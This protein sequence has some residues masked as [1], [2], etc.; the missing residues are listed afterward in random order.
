L[1]DWLVAVGATP[2][3]GQIPLYD[4]AHSVAQTTPPTQ[5]WIYLPTNVNDSVT[6]NRT[7]TQY[8]TFNTPVEAAADAQCGRVVHTDIHVKAAPAA[9]GESKDKSDPGTGGTPFPTGCTS[10]T[11]SAQEK[12]LE[13]LFFDLSACVQP[14]TDRPVPPPVP[15]PGLPSTPPGVTPVPPP[16]PPPPPPPPPPVIP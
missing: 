8:M 7:S 11:L 1:A 13:F 2:T 16:V 6:P 12:A 5:R 10:V 3:R 9:P 4:S 15:P 14:D